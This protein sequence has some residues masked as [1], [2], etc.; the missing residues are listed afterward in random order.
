MTNDQAIDIGIYTSSLLSFTGPSLNVTRAVSGDADLTEVSF[1]RP[2]DASSVL[3]VPSFMS[4]IEMSTL[5]SQT[6][7][8]PERVEAASW[9]LREFSIIKRDEA[10]F[11]E[12]MA[13]VNETVMHAEGQ[14]KAYAD[15]NDNGRGSLL[16]EQEILIV[17][18]DQRRRRTHLAAASIS[19][20]IDIVERATK[21]HPVE[22]QQEIRR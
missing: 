14:S 20:V 6:Q 15:I 2:S 9:G 19:E 3:T 8:L 5:I 16:Q 12:V 4:S 22:I 18:Q 1:F 10:N 7:S 17:A 11:S 21:L 13:L